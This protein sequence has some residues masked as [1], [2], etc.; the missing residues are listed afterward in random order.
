MATRILLTGSLITHISRHSA[1][2]I[3]CVYQKGVGVLVFHKI[4]NQSDFSGSSVNSKYVAFFAVLIKEVFHLKFQNRVI[5]P[6]LYTYVIGYVCPP[7]AAAAEVINKTQTVP[8]CLFY[9]SN[10]ILARTIAAE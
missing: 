6:F 5:H 2:T 8:L 7:V 9:S 10:Y 1:I 3:S 4:T